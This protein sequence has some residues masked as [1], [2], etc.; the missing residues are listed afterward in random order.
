MTDP[1]VK[2]LLF[3]SSKKITTNTIPFVNNNTPSQKELSYQDHSK[4]YTNDGR[5]IKIMVA[6]SM[7]ELVS[8]LHILKTIK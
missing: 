3:R 8:H 4:H 1:K 2:I 7:I 6:T 5:S